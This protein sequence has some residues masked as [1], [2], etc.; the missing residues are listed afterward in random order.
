[1]LETDTPVSYQGKEARP[2]DV[3]TSM[4]EVARLKKLNRLTVAE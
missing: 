2:K 1:L 3:L 4:E